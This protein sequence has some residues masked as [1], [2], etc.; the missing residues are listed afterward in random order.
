VTQLV[1]CHTDRTNGCMTTEAL[2]QCPKFAHNGDRLLLLL[3]DGIGTSQHNN[4]GIEWPT[5]RTVHSNSWLKHTQCNSSKQ[6]HMKSSNT[7]RL[8]TQW[9]TSPIHDGSR[10]KP[11]EYEA[12]NA[13]CTYAAAVYRKTL[14]NVHMFTLQIFRT[15]L[16]NI[17]WHNR[18]WMILNGKLTMLELLNIY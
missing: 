11:T 2:L 1:R 7:N 5:E 17:G 15:V 4:T 18:S 12:D 9:H 14:H 6:R 16:F 3:S 10:Q 8:T 13:S